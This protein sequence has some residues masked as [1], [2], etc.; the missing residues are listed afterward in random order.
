LFLV[1]RRFVDLPER[2]GQIADHAVLERVPPNRPA[3]ET[4]VTSKLVF[5]GDQPSRSGSVEGAA[6]PL[7]ILLG[8]LT[9]GGQVLLTKLRSSLYDLVKY[10]NQADLPDRP[11]ARPLV[12][13]IGA[14]EQ[15]HTRSAA[16]NAIDRIDEIDRAACR[17]AVSS[18]FTVDLMADRYLGLYRLIL[19]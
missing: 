5:L 19:G 17:A 4:L 18:R 6:G 14:L 15:A 11:N 16:V 12:S 13:F 8:E 1:D 2:R 3:T 7:L 10:L 9:E